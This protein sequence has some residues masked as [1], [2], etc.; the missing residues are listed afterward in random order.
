MINNF[1]LNFIDFVLRKNWT[2]NRKEKV[3]VN[4]SEIF[5]T[6]N[7][8]LSSLKKNESVEN[9]IPNDRIDKF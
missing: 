2:D 7:I 5:S 9:F 4:T 1:C 8:F 3:K 6:W